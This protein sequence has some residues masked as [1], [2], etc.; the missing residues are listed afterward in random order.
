[1]TNHE[2]QSF[3]DPLTRTH[4]RRNWR[5]RRW[6]IVI[7]VALSM[8]GVTVWIVITA[9][10]GESREATRRN[11]AE[12]A[13]CLINYSESRGHLPF[14]VRQEAEQQS[15]QDGPVNGTG[16][17]LYS[18]RVSL[19]VYLQA[20]RGSWDKA[21]PWDHP[22]NQELVDFSS[23]YAYDVD[24]RR[25]NASFPPTNVLAITG[26]GTAFGDGSE[27]PRAIKDIPPSCILAVETRE[28][29]IPWPAP[30]DFDVRTMPKTINAPDG[31]GISS[32]NAGGF[33]VLFA[34]GHVW[35]L[36]NSVPFETLSKLFTVT[37]AKK[38]HRAELLGP[39]IM[40]R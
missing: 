38:H 29:G 2:N 36:S 34:D 4:T 21:Q 5:L 18:W 20:W 25:G 14:A 12:V 11:F 33:H 40:R 3:E 31:K 6:L 16:R 9:R 35:F 15:R 30:G 24:E 37:D 10:D 7:G 17:A 32:R 8:L 1:V 39:F 28:S 22:S 26:P 27:R 13:L 19:I 23:F